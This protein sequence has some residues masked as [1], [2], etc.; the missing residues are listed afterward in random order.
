MSYAE[1]FDAVLAELPGD[2]A[3]FECHVTVADPLR[4]ADARVAL[5]RANARPVRRPD[6]HDFAITVANTHGRGARAGVVRSALRLLDDLGIEGRAWAGAV[7]DAL[8]PAPAH[9]YGP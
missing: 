8:R 2:W 6:D 5:A 7:Y 3:F 4:L 1:E 9:R